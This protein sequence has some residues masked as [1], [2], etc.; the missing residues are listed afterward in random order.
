MI[1]GH[2]KLLANT[3]WLKDPGC[4]EKE[5]WQGGMAALVKTRSW[6]S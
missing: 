6:G 1:G 5:E 2:G 3:K 4:L